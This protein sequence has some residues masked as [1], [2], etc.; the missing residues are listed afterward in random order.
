MGL[1]FAKLS[2]YWQLRLFTIGL[3]VALVVYAVVMPVHSDESSNPSPNQSSRPTSERSNGAP[4]VPA[5][6]PSASLSA[7]GSSSSS[8]LHSGSRLW[9]GENHAAADQLGRTANYYLSSKLPRDSN[10]LIRALQRAAAQDDPTAEFLLGHALQAGFGLSPDAA[11]GRRWMERASR[12]R[13]KMPGGQRNSSASSQGMGQ[14][15]I[16]YDGSVSD[17]SPAENESAIAASG[18]GTSGI[19]GSRISLPGENSSGSN[20]V[21]SGSNGV[22]DGQVIADGRGASS[23]PYG[24]TSPT[25]FDQAF[26]HF[27]NLAEDG[28][29]IAQLFR[30][31][32]YDRGDEV[33]KDPILAAHW[34]RKAAEQGSVSA[35][36]NLGELFRDGDGCTER[37][38]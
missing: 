18:V 11:E 22:T 31:L 2:N 34:Y 32:A 5:D 25:S 15:A 8:G 13:A 28:D 33:V 30:G 1:L 24:P 27:S 7:S 38:R 4:S 10:D 6:Q 14:S 26:H 35:I 3:C 29:P 36:C 16:A 20:G 23:L 21:S 17:R 9:I 19:G 12:V 37:R